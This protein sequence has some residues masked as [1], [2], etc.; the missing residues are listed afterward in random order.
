MHV[1]A[2]D[3]HHD[4]FLSEILHFRYAPLDQVLAESDIVTIHVPD[5]AHTH[6]LINRGNI[7]KMKPGSLLINTARGGIVENQA[8][9]E[10]LDNH[11]IAGA[12]LDVLEGEE[13]SRKKAVSA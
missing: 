4:T 10:A 13:I 12:G 1:I 9:I 11:T 2:C 7:R 5:N 6:H 8:L 3:V